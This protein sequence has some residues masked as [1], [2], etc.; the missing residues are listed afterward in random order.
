[1]TILV[2]THLTISTARKPTGWRAEIPVRSNDR[3]LQGRILV[4]FYASLKSSRVTEAGGNTC[5]KA[6]PLTSTGRLRG[7]TARG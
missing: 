7:A 2:P 5:V 3:M 1:M 6:D 4:R